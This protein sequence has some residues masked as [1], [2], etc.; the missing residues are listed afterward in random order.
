MKDLEPRRSMLHFYEKLSIRE[1]IQS[2]YLLSSYYA[3]VIQ[4]MVF[5]FK[6]E[7]VTFS[8]IIKCTWKGFGVRI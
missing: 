7:K 2:F 6:N 5:L 3:T 1:S 4:G 8:K